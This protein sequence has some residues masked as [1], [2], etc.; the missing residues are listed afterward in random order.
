MYITSDAQAIAYHLPT[1]AQLALQAAEER[2][3]SSHPLQNSIYM[4]S[5]GMEYPFGQFKPAVLILFPPSSLGPSLR[6]ALSPY[7]TA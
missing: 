5:Y 2:K 6:M 1:N 3:L 7:N 4:M